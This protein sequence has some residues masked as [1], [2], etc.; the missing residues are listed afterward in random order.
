MHAAGDVINLSR[1]VG[2]VYRGLDKWESR[3]RLTPTFRATMAALIEKT[4]AAYWPSVFGSSRGG[5][6]GGPPPFLDVNGCC[7][8]P[9][10]HD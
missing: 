1:Q 4:T 7:S 10:D 9:G 6:Q 5:L 2:K 3:S 8:L